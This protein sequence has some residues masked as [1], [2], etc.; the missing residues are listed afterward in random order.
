MEIEEMKELWS[1]S[2]RSLEA[3]VRLNAMLLRQWN[4]RKADTFLERLSRGIIFELISKVIASVLIGSFAAAHVH[5]PRFLIPALVL[6]AYIMALVAGGGRQLAQIKA[7]DYDAPVVE[8]QKDLADLRLRRIRT[9][10]WVLLFAPLMW[11]PLLIVALRAIFGVDI[12]AAG[13][14]W[15][16][17][18]ALFGL[19]VIP[20]A[21][22]IAKRYRSRIASHTLLRLLADEIAGRSLAEALDRLDAIRRFEQ[23]GSSPGP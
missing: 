19:A 21:I 7:V 18:N 6:D 16:V 2:N 1:Q 9:T 13:A 14:T 5:E 12:Y 17:A 3:S 15:L 11:L 10:L 23:D 20:L 8:I 4:L 22:L